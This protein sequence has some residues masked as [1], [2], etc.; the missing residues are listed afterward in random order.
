[1]YSGYRIA[2]DGGSS[3]SFGND[4]T[5]NVEIFGVDNGWHQQLVVINNQLLLITS[6]AVV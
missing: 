3:M 2:F 4:F 5:R 1:M 6:G